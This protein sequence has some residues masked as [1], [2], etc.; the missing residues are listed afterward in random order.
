MRLL[1][2][3]TPKKGY[4]F[5][6]SGFESSN[7]GGGGGG[8]SFDFTDDETAV[9]QYGNEV[10]YCKK[11][12]VPDVLFTSGQYTI[13][14]STTYKIRFALGGAECSQ[15]GGYRISKYLET[16]YFTQYGNALS[17]LTATISSSDIVS[18]SGYAYIFYTKNN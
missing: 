5:A 2:F 12:S 13:P 11:I 8:G 1:P 15:S 16:K 6:G 14:S 10:L 3:L 4:Q 9:G 17:I 18:N 7:G